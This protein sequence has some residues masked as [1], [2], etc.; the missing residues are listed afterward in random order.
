MRID[1]LGLEAFVSIGDR[2]SF[3]RAAAH[4][5]LSQT[6][7]SHRL[8]KLEDDLG[9]KLLA[10][11]TRSVSLTPA[12]LELLPKARSLIE[13][14]QTSFEDLRRQGKEKQERLV[15]A[16]LPTLA[17]HYLSRVLKEF[18]DTHP[19]V[20]VRVHDNSASEIAEL[21]KSGQ[22]EFGLT[23]VSAN[24]W[25][26]DIEPLIK[27]PFV[28]ACPKGHPLAD[29]TVASWGD[30]EGLPLV[31]I[32]AQTG[33]RTLIDDALGPRREQMTWRYEVQHLAS[34]VSMVAAGVGLAIVPRLA[35]NEADTPGIVAVTLRNPGVSR[36]LGLITRRGHPLSPAASALRG[37]IERRIRED[38]A[39]DG[40]R[41]KAKPKAAA[42]L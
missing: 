5:N 24:R 15:V 38:T 2:G 26:L 13:D 7:L 32:S 14:L 16:C 6:A 3:N 25:D 11:T 37:M 1:Y 20:S 35:V 36:T 33:N 41:A 8:K 34:A 40:G 27:E 12:G 4:L 19:G 42:K 10:R 18:G 39:R 21:V 29:Q 17:V 22:A 9:V 28:L 23:I 31:R 30:L